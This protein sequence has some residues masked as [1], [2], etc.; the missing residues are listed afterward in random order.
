VVECK[1]NFEKFVWVELQRKRKR[2]RGSSTAWADIIAGAM[3]EEKASAHFARNDGEGVQPTVIC[4]IGHK[5]ATKG[6][7][8]FAAAIMI[9]N[10]GQS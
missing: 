7:L 9:I 3:M 10:T 8:R 5:S 4:L 1:K 2:R 6:L